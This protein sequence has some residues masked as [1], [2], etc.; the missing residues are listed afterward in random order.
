MENYKSFSIQPGGTYTQVSD[1]YARMC[2]ILRGP[3]TPLTH[4]IHF[5]EEICHQE[6]AWSGDGRASSMR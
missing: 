4:I 2:R 5:L 1:D 3:D 6:E